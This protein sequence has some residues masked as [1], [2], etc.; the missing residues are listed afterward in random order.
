MKKI[1]G[2]AGGQGPPLN[3]RVRRSREN[4]ARENDQYR[5]N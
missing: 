1:L 5:D 2:Q 4:E 3:F